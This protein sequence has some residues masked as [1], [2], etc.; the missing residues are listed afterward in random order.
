MTIRRV[1]VQVERRGGAAPRER[2]RRP[3]V[4]HDE[5]GVQAESFGDRLIGL[6]RAGGEEYETDP[7]RTQV[8]PNSGEGLPNRGAVPA[9]RTPVDQQ[10]LTVDRRNERHLVAVEVDAG[11]VREDVADVTLRSDALDQ[12]RELDVV[13]WTDPLQQPERPDMAGER[14]HLGTND[15]GIDSQ[16]RIELR[17]DLP[18]RGLT[19]EALPEQG[20]ALV[21]HDRGRPAVEQDQLV[22]DRDRFHTRDRDGDEGPVESVGRNGVSSRGARWVHHRRASAVRIS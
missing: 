13:G 19:I 11:H 3:A 5:A 4:E 6:H 20:A 9:V 14:H 15:L 7:L 17:N 12:E 18:D 8:R 16:R 2:M 22:G 21:E 10:R 1:G